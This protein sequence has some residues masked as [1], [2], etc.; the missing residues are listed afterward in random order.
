MGVRELAD[1]VAELALKEADGVVSAHGNQSE[2]R[3]IEKA[4][5]GRVGFK[6]RIGLR[7]AGDSG[8]VDSSGGRG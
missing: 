4:T 1:V 5:G 7:K 8:L 2:M 3:E 6:G